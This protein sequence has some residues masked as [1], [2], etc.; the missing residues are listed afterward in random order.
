MTIYK[1][2]NSKIKSKKHL[3]HVFCSSVQTA[4]RSKITS[5]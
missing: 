2:S 5:S 4:H 3:Y 1:Q